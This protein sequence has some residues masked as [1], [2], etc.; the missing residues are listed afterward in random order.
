MDSGSQRTYITSSLQANF[1]LPVS[2]RE[3]LQIKTFGSSE[4]KS[5]SCDVVQLKFLTQNDDNI[6]LTAL[7][8]LHICNPLTS[9]PDSH[10]E[11]CYSHLLGLELTD[12]A[13]ASDALEVDMLIGAH[14]Y[15]SLVTGK[16]VRREGGPTAIQT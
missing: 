10:S 5:T 14:V 16:V 6:L 12:S 15:W 2:R 1:D 7:V 11:E 8:V 4:C 3:S 9:Q 13:E